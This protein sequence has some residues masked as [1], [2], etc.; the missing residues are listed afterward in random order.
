MNTSRLSHFHFFKIKFTDEN[1]P[2][3]PDYRI[4]NNANREGYGI[5]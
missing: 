4:F 2:S 3:S 1:K 5:L